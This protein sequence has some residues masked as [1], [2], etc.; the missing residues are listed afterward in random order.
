MNF[1][2]IITDPLVI[3]YSII[4]ICFIGIGL[5]YFAWI[6]S[7]WA[8]ILISLGIAFIAWG[9]SRKSGFLIKRIEDISKKT[10]KTT[11]RLTKS[12]LL[13]TIGVF[14]DRRLG[15]RER[16]GVF[17]EKSNCIPGYIS[18]SNAFKIDFIEYRYYSSFS[19]WKCR[20]YVERALIFQENFGTD[21]ESK[22]IHHVDCLFQ[23]LCS[24]HIF[25]FVHFHINIL[26]LEESKRHL[27]Y[28]YN[29]L[30]TLNLFNNKDDKE[31]RRRYRILNNLRYLKGYSTTPRFWE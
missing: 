30:L 27:Q 9:I 23:D 6:S 16:W 20:T 17:E 2:K 12:S 29:Q 22:L 28:I 8:S 4:G 21:E 11:G 26:L 1:K 25:F 7:G 3:I 24:E 14:E 10:E 18:R 5:L 31:Q 15:L 19:I 13:E